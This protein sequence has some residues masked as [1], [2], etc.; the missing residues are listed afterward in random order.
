LGSDFS[1][2][3]QPNLLYWYR[4]RRQAARSTLAAARAGLLLFLLAVRLQVPDRHPRLAQR[5]GKA[6][7]IALLSGSFVQE[8]GG[9][10]A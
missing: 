5:S 6:I 10:S 2:S 9:E 1:D 3:S 7:G 8:R 4:R